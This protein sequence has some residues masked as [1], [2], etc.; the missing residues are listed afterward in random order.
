MQIKKIYLQGFRNYKD[1]FFDFK[2]QTTMIVGP[3]AAG[4]T[5]ILEAVNLLATGESF[6]AKK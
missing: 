5:N 3:N 4:K 1:K 6:R 2:P